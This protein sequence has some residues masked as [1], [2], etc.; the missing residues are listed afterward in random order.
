MTTRSLTLFEHQTLHL[1]RHGTAFRV[2]EAHGGAVL[3]LDDLVGLDEAGEALVTSPRLGPV[4]SASAR[5][6]VK[7]SGWVGVA[8]VGDIQI[9]VLPK[10]SWG[11][12]PSDVEHARGLFLEM[13]TY[14]GY[15]PPWTDLHAEQTL[16]R[17]PLYETLVACYVRSLARALRDGPWSD[18][19]ERTEHLT[20]V[21]GRIAFPEQLR[22][23]VARPGRIAC[24]HQPW[25]ADHL[26]NQVLVA[27]LR[28]AR[29]LARTSRVRR[30]LS[31][32]EDHLGDIDPGNV[33]AKDCERVRFTRLNRAYEGPFRWARLILGTHRPNLRGGRQD[34]F[35]LLFPMHEVFE[36][37]LA[38]IAHRY[39]AGPELRV[40]SQKVIGHLVHHA[41]GKRVR[42]KPDLLFTETGEAPIAVDAKY[43]RYP[44]LRASENDLRQVMAY[45]ALLAE[46]A[47]RRRVV[48][49]YP[50]GAE[51]AER[52]E[53]GTLLWPRSAGEP[54][55]ELVVASVR[56]GKHA[57]QASARRARV[58]HRIAELVRLAPSPKIA[59]QLGYSAV[60]T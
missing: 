56:L 50:A 47:P 24:Q 59:K 37:W 10:T 34:T 25:V 43:K 4:F 27:A 18:Y 6:R 8:R 36:A 54:I 30:E 48:L 3:T 26:L 28:A 60:N 15:L 21:R 57:E 23:N 32:C 20:T 46:G 41:K 49:L 31:R 45:Q 1:E 55:I 14:A 13:L 35:G 51:E 52:T 11:K 38:R 17:L 58:A 12:A 53:E 22:R 42:Q 40:E 7:A 44:G 19:V 9:E 5:G 29:P 39:L 33:T 16:E 2:P